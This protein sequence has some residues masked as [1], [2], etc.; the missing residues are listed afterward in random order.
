MRCELCKRP[1]QYRVCLRCR[2]AEHPEHT[3]R[4]THIDLVPARFAAREEADLNTDLYNQRSAHA[5][6]WRLAKGF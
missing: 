4:I 2:W 3:K 6:L 1:T 5:R